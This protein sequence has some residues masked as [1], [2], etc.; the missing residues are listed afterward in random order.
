MYPLIDYIIY[1]Y[2]RFCWLFLARHRV[3]D[4]FTRSDTTPYVFW[5]MRLNDQTLSIYSLAYGIHNFICTYYICIVYRIVF[6]L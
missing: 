5:D 1:T 4:T 6:I 2:S 3:G